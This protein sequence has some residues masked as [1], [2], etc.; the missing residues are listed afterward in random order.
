LAGGALRLSA[1]VLGVFT[2]HRLHLQRFEHLAIR[3]VVGMVMLA[4]QITGTQWSL[5]LCVVVLV[6]LTFAVRRARSSSDRTGLNL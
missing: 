2:R 5:A 3:K 6:V 4:V 1:L